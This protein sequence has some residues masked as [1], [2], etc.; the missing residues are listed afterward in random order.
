M[1]DIIK[2]HEDIQTACYEYRS[3]AARNSGVASSKERIK[4]LM[5]TN[6]D[7]ILDALQK[8]KDSAREM[9]MLHEQIVALESELAA[10]DAENISLRK[11]L[12][13]KQ[14][15]EESQ[16]KGRKKAV[17]STNKVETKTLTAVVE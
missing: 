15:Q 6:R 10:V 13:N 16:N 11:E 14:S 17:R 7:Q 3:A 12:A 9:E 1:S 2:L 4:N 5:F 8:A